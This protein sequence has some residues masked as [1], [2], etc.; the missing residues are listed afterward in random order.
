MEP[1][2][3]S[4]IIPCL[5]ESTMVR[6]RL[7]ALQGLRRAGHELILVDGGSDDGTLEL[8]GSLVDQMI[9]SP[10]GRA[11]QMNAGAKAAQGEILWFLHLDSRLP[12]GAA[13]RVI[14]SVAG[15]WGRFDVRLSGRHILFRV[16]ERLMNLRSCVSGIATGDQG[17]FVH[18]E[19]F[20]ASDG[21]PD[22]P[23]MEDIVLSR[24]LKRRRRPVCLRPPLVTSSRRWERHGILRTVLLMWYLRLAYFLGASPE[25]LARLYNPR[26]ASRPLRD[27]PVV[28]S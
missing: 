17:I 16:I 9:D 23:L 21:F 27:R 1:T 2:R 28:L 24:R 7:T 10:T 25:Y 20:F 6:E 3:L 5:N 19:L 26:N 22:I 18:R 14:D 15:G 8:A 13:Q 4:I 12:P 11:R